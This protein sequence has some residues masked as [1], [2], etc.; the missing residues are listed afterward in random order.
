MYI[1]TELSILIFKYAFKS[2]YQICK[3]ASMST[4]TTFEIQC[5]FVHKDKSVFTNDFLFYKL[6][7]AP[8][9]LG[10]FLILR[11]KPKS[12]MHY[13]QGLNYTCLIVSG[14]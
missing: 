2:H 14:Y 7:I 11:I 13:I 12:M 5:I 9:N 6:K 4:T 10:I 1:Q 3:Y 8:V